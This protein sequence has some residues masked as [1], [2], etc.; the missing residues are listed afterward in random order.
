VQ[1]T[2]LELPVPGT[3]HPLVF[4]GRH[5]NLVYPAKLAA[6]QLAH[7]Q[8]KLLPQ[9]TGLLSEAGNHN[10]SKSEMQQWMEM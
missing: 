7:L 3:G 1:A 9:T 6:Q 4:L 10:E 2:P 5:C 8:A